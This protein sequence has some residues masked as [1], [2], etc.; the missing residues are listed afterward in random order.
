[1]SS[2]DSSQ[3]PHDDDDDIDKTPFDLIGPEKVAQI[4]TNFYEAM[5]RDEPVLA[6]LH[7]CD[8]DGRVDRETQERFAL[9]LVGWLGGPQLFV[10]RYGHPR[11]RMRH[12]HVPVDKAMRDAWLRCMATALDAAEL[13]RPLREFLDERFYT[14]ANHLINRAETE[15]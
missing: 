8:D 3:P 2:N 14:M 9:F 4:A 7:N 15:S 5:A 13:A 11:L 6:R 10:E 1:M 12:G